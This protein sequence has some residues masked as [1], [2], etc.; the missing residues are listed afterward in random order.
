MAFPPLFHF[1]P[2]KTPEKGCLDVR[3]Q[4]GSFRLHF[5]KSVLSE[6]GHCIQ[7]GAPSS[8]LFHLSH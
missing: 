3:L 8:S 4:H 1:I 6:T 5:F 7:N 2:N